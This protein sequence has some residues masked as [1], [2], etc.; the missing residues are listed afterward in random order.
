MEH[1][2]FKAFTR[3]LW[4]F[5]TK[6]APLARVNRGNTHTVCIAAGG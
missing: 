3:V 6:F 5:T 1:Y 4:W 2:D